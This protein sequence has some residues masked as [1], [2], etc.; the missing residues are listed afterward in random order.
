MKISIFKY[1][2]FAFFTILYKKSSYL[3]PIFTLVF[4]TIIGLIFKF[5]INEKYLGLSSYLYIFLL[6]IITVIFSAIKSLNIFKDLDQEGLE[7]ISFSKPIS[8]NNLILGKLLCLS[9][10]GLIWSSI[11]LISALVSLYANYSFITLVLTSLL[12]W[13][14]GL[15]TYLLIS[16]ITAILS[17]KLTQKIALTIPLVLFIFLSIIGMVLSSNTTSN[18]NKVGYYLNQK[19]PYHHSNNQL[20][21]EA[22]FINNKDELLVIP[23]G[24]ENKEF[25]DEQVQYLKKATEVSNN[26][27]TL[28]TTY[29]WFSIPYQLINV[30]N[31][32]NKNIFNQFSNSSSNL[33][34]FIYYNDLDDISYKYKLVKNASYNKYSVLKD[35]KLV[36]MYAIPGLLQSHTILSSNNINNK[37][38]NSRS[39]DIIYA[40]KNANDINTNFIEDENDFSRENNL[41]GVLKWNN[42]YQVLNDKTFNQ[43]AKR[44]VDNFIKQHINLKEYQTIKDKNNYFNNLHNKL[45]DEIS[46]YLNNDKS[47]INNYQ[48]SNLTIFDSRAIIDKKLESIYEKQLYLATSL[49]NYIYFN[50]QNS[51]LLQALLKD[52]NKKDSYLDSQ[53]KIKVFDHDYYIGGYDKYEKIIYEDKKENSKETKI[54]IRYRLTESK[55]NFLFNSSPNLFAITRDKQIFNKNILFGIWI[56]VVSLLFYLVFYMYVRK[57]YK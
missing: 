47:E 13:F 25:N 32:K 46:K 19:Y 52:V 6:L 40:R 49:M 4:S 48:N 10:Y 51:I 14:V 15:I 1:S 37:N 50:Y 5:V 7:I 55:T 57:D 3:L 36:E 56:I 24:S 34:N 23:N 22:Y 38:I 45:V 43:I 8:R 39:R 9:F 44:F 21:S 41:V 54:K 18:L 17:Y 12:L 35:D 20:N 30:F 33:N 28:W 2:Q 26:S 53:I 42:V 27:S 16:L 29:S 31:F 11:L